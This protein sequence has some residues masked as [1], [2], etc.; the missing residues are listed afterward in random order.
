[1]IQQRIPAWLKR[2]EREAVHPFDFVVVNTLSECVSRVGSMQNLRE[3][4]AWS[5]KIKVH[6]HA[7]DD[8]TY[9]F[10]IKEYEPAPIILR[11]TLHRLDND[12][13]YVS[14][15]AIARVLL[16]LRD[17]VGLL[18]LIWG[19][20]VF[21]GFFVMILFLPPLAVFTWYYWRGTRRERERLTAE[22]KDT[23]G[24]RGDA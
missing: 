8:R 3:H 4:D 15:V 6:L 19:L 2:F 10:T 14:G 12:T 24:W 1:M 23:L 21:V 7:K 11:G 20:S 16:E 13:T 17:V 5:P 18:L 9:T 22:M